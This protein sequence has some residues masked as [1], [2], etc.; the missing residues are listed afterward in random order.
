MNQP[1]QIQPPTP[2]ST[3]ALNEVLAAQQAAI[4]AQGVPGYAQRIADLDAVLR[5][6]SSNQDRLLEAVCA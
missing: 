1:A 6:V 5:M 4:R 2:S 3:A